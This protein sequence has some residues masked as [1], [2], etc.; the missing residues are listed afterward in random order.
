MLV[1]ENKV[2]R[3]CESTLSKSNNIQHN[4][5]SINKR[6]QIGVYYKQKLQIPFCEL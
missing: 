3:Q 4:F 1:L 5:Y 2:I 6:L